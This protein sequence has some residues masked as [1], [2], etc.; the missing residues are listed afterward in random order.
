MALSVQLQPER[1]NW[2]RQLHRMTRTSTDPEIVL[3]NFY[4]EDEQDS[5]QESHVLNCAS[6]Y[7]HDHIQKKAQRFL[8]E[9]NSSTDHG[10]HI[11]TS[12]IYSQDTSFRRSSYEDLDEGECTKY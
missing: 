10:E 11:R 5:S 1:R 2:Y 7:K 12:S 6:V 9:D 4:E 8:S 3:D